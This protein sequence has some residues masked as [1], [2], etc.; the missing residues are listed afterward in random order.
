[1]KTYQSQPIEGENLFIGFV[2]NDEEHFQ[3][4][5]DVNKHHTTILVNESISLIGLKFNLLIYTEDSSQFNKDFIK[6]LKLRTVK[7]S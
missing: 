2:S 3:S 1:M 5:K 6:A 4:F 7:H